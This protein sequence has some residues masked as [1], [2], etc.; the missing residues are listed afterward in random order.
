MASPFY[1]DFVFLRQTGETWT[2][3]LLDPHH[4][5]LADAPA[6]AVGLAKYAAKHGCEFNRIELIIVRGKEDIR[7]IDLIDEAKRE[8]VLAVKTKEHLALL[9]EEFS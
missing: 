9:F 4:I 8:K 1:P 6:K 3:D 5:D 2:V 7:R